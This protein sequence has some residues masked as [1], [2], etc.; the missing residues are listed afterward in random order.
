MRCACVRA[1]DAGDTPRGGIR[2]QI[3]QHVANLHRLQLK[4]LRK[5]LDEPINCKFQMKT[6]QNRLM[7]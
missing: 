2:S 3:G 5:Y 7:I 1:V 4:V 6:Q